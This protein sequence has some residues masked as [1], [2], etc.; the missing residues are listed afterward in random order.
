MAL[1]L[2]PNLLYILIPVRS[3]LSL[4]TFYL[5]NKHSFHRF[6]GTAHP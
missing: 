2:L 1:W 4:L 6:D 3:Y 5:N